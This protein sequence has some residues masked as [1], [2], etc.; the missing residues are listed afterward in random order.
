MSNNI[1]KEKLRPKNVIY[2]KEYIE[3]FTFENEREAILFH[4]YLKA[5][6]YID[7]LESTSNSEGG[8]SAEEILN[9]ELS[10]YMLEIF[11]NNPIFKEWVKDAMYKYASQL[12]CP[13]IS[14]E[15]IEELTNDLGAFRDGV[16]DI[17][18]ILFSIYET[19]G[20]K[21]IDK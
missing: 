9:N 21:F 15:D 4:A 2:T 1:T 17:E 6:E 3:P 7:S 13:H 18:Q 12:Q 20:V 11:K 14:D 8:K 19:T 16:I 10:D 5:E